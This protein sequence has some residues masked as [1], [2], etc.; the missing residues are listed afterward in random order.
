MVEWD[1]NKTGAW[2]KSKYA[3]MLGNCMYRKGRFY[4]ALLTPNPGPLFVVSLRGENSVH[5]I[6]YREMNSSLKADDLDLLNSS[7]LWVP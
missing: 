2:I 1:G 7:G 5:Q 6:Q 4:Y 3:D